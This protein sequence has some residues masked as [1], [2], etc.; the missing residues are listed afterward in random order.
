MSIIKKVQYSRIN[1]ITNDYLLKKSKN[2]LVKFDPCPRDICYCF[3]LIKS[4]ER[5]KITSKLV[6]NANKCKK[7]YFLMQYIK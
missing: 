6:Q 5:S 2:N 7:E 4:P 3:E 1:R